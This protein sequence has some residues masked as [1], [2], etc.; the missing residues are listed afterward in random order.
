MKHVRG[1]RLGRVQFVGAVLIAAL[2][3]LVLQACG[4]SGDE[5]L[6]V[7]SRAPAFTLPAAS[8]GDVSLAGYEG[9]RPVLLY[10]HMADG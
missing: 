3:A 1:I 4:G 9:A 5:T 10:F 8:G 7:G 6:K 2:L